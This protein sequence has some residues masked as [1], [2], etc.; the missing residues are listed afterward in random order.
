MLDLYEAQGSIR[1]SVQATKV[2][3][4]AFRLLVTLLFT[5]MHPQDAQVL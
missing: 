3:R 4:T 5:H 2:K 1:S